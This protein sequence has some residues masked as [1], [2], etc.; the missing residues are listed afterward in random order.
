MN[1]IISSICLNDKAAITAYLTCKKISKK[2]HVYSNFMTASF[3]TQHKKIPIFH[4]CSS[5]HLRRSITLYQHC[6]KIKV[7]TIRNF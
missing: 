5:A 2:I 3:E 1:K 6:R 4:K 7:T